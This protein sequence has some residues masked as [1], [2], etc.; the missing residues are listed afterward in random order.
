MSKVEANSIFSASQNC[1]GG[2]AELLC[3]GLVGVRLAERFQ[4]PHG[5][6]VVVQLVGEANDPEIHLLV[7]SPLVMQDLL[8]GRPED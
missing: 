4:G 7:K 6:L 5:E 8:D 1:E 2:V 3:N